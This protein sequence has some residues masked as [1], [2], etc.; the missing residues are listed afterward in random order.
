MATLF[1]GVY[2]IVGWW[3]ACLFVAYFLVAAKYWPWLGY[4]GRERPEEGEPI[5]RSSEAPAA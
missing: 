3:L 4:V 2:H 1:L 5:S